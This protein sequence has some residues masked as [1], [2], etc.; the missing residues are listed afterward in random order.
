MLFQTLHAGRARA[1]SFEP[2]QLL[3]KSQVP[4]CTRH[5]Q[6]LGPH[7]PTQNAHEQRQH[8]SAEEE[9]IL[10]EWVEYQS[11][12]ARPLNKRTLLQKVERVTGM[13][14]FYHGASCSVQTF[15]H[16]IY[17]PQ[18]AIAGHLGLSAGGHDCL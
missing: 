18:N 16:L 1:M 15:L 7:E 12:I 8:L 11:D 3:E 9:M 4:H 14:R 2:F 6:W 13:R 5:N 10:C 17:V